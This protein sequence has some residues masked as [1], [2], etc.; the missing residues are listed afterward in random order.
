[1]ISGLPH[2]LNYLSY[3]QAMPAR[4]P[5]WYQA[6]PSS[7]RRIPLADVETHTQ[8]IGGAQGTQEKRARKDCRSQWG[9]GHQ[10]NMVHKIN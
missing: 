5:D 4:R 9:L 8:M 3:P 2:A 1:M 7:E 6:Q 10:E